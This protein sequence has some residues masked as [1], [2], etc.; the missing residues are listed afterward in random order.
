MP[1]F[2]FLYRITEATAI[3]AI[4]TLEIVTNEACASTTFDKS[5]TA[6]WLPRMASENVRLPEVSY[7]I[8]LF[9]HMSLWYSTL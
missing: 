2:C 6:S 9:T 4:T 5:A 1:L 3:M 7:F 8:V